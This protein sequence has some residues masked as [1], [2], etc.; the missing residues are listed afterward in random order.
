MRDFYPI[1][2]GKPA[3]A[4]DAAPT[5]G[6]F[7]RKIFSHAFV[8]ACPA[9]GCPMEKTST[10]TVKVFF[11]CSRLDGGVQCPYRGQAPRVE[12]FPKSL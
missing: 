3:M 1:W 4:D 12:F 11:R 8:P 7:P 9:H 5:N 2:Q 10:G 6:R